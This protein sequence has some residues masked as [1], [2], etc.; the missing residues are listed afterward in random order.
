MKNP[1]SKDNIFFKKAP[2]KKPGGSGKSNAISLSLPALQL[3]NLTRDKIFKYFENTWGLTELLFSGL[4]NKSA[5]YKPPYHNLRHPLIFYYGHSAVCYVNKLR[6]AGIITNP[7]NAYFENIFEI[8]VDEMSWDDLSKNTMQWPEINDLKHYRETV[9]NTVKNLIET[10]A[11]FDKT[12]IGL[13]DPAWA[14]MLA[15]EHERIHLE[16]S[17]VLIRELPIDLLEKPSHWPKDFTSEQG[18]IEQGEDYPPYP[19]NSYPNNKYITVPTQTINL[20]KTKETPFYGWDNEYGH[21]TMKVQEFKASQFLISNGEFLRFVKDQGYHDPAYWVGQAWEWLC[22]RNVKHP[23]FWVTEGPD[24]LHQYKLR[25]CF[26]I[27]PMQWSWPVIVNYYEA[28]AYCLWLSQKNSSEKTNFRENNSQENNKT[29]RLLTEAE[30]HCL[31]DPK[32]YDLASNICLENRE[33]STDMEDIT[34]IGDIKNLEHIANIGLKYGSEGPVDAFVKNEHGFYDVIGNVW[35]WMEDHFCPLPGFKP[36]PYYNDFSIP[37]FDGKHHMMMGGSFIS[38]GDEATPW[39]RYHFRPHFFQHAGFRVVQSNHLETSCMDCPPPYVGRGPCCHKNSALTSATSTMSENNVQSTTSTSQPWSQTQSQPQSQSQAQS[40]A[41]SQNPIYETETLL[42][43]YLLLHYGTYSDVLTI[44]DVPKISKSSKSSKISVPPDIS[45]ISDIPTK[46]IDFPKRCADLI[47]TSVQKYNI[48]CNRAL[49]IGCAV[50]R[51][52][53]EISPVFQEVIGIDNS[54]SFIKTA[55]EL[56]AGKTIHYSKKE[57]GDITLPLSI[58]LKPTNKKYDNI[59]FEL[60]DACNI[61]QTLG[62]FNVILMANVLCR[63]PNPK[64][65]LLNLISSP[66]F[67]ANNGLFIILSPYSWLE[68]FTDKTEWLGGIERSNQKIYTAETLKKLLSSQNLTLLEEFEMPFLIREHARKFQLIIS[69]GMI[70]RP[71]L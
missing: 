45:V 65:C 39:S 10:H 16:T 48:E 70:W 36:H 53:F 24:G 35:Q 54:E 67:L 33:D 20:G 57:E 52:C 18:E 5:F 71:T 19:N 25:T 56:K 38:T 68:S 7:I 8:G 50:G 42:N 66:G 41:Q 55:N 6:L 63:V 29:Y 14:L 49:D 62:S 34:D 3:Q 28:K 46:F 23:S 44:S 69:H 61:S 59:I 58:T 60:A 13:Q 4:K 51:V 32:Q 15:L 31:R 12:Q 37:C 64:Q 40:Q 26:E 43:E 1:K 47:K 30:H 21:K 17:S 11:A 22:F 9:F 27:I 2:R